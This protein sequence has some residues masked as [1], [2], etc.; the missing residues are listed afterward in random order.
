MESYPTLK[1]HRLSIALF[2]PQIAANTGNIARLCVASGTH[3]HLVRPMGFI[4]GDRQLKRSAMDYWP[5][6]KFT[7]H[8]DTDAFLEAMKSVRFV[9]FT[10]KSNRSF[11]DL[12]KQEADCLV[13]GSE[14]AGL[15]E[16]FVSRHRETAVRIPQMPDERCLN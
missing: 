10:S 8:D 4:L 9:L 14:T 7:L 15:P 1:P 3:L 11:W 2:Q 13:F 5:R 16:A 6:L 12:P